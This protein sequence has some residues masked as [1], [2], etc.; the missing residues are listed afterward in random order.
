VREGNL[1]LSPDLVA[2]DNLVDV[3]KLIPVFIIFKLIAIQRLEFRSTRDRQV[4]CFRSVEA[5]LVKQVEI[6]FVS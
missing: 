6:I 1:V 5:L 2:D 3:V 4:Q